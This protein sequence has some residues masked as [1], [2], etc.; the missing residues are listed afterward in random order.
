MRAAAD[1]RTLLGRMVVFERVASLGSFK[2]AGEELRLAR[3][4]VSHAVATLETELGARLLHRTT[5]SVACTPAGLA[6]RTRCEAIIREGTDALQ[7]LEEHVA[8]PTGV[9]RVT[10]PVG[11]LTEQ[12]VAPVVAGLI[13]AHGLRAELR[14]TDER[15][16]LS[17]GDVDVAIRLGTPQSSTLK[18]RSFGSIEHMFV[19]AP[20]VAETIR[21]EED[22]LRVPFVRHLRMRG[23]YVITRPDGSTLS[24]QPEA[25]TWV[26]DVSTMLAMVR[27]GAG[28]CMVPTLYAL[29]DIRAGTLVRVLEDHRGPGARLFA[30]MPAGEQMPARTRRFLDA[31]AERVRAFL[32]APEG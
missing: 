20:D 1:L 4:A 14:V 24:L 12:L 9:L 13:R 19:A 5:R 8:H 16:D 10:A 31:L 15:L 17:G 25:T 7:E 29:G 28:L 18:M 22:L 32:E 23:A 27:C 21:G 11:P 3:S 6:F 26:G 2:A 30:L